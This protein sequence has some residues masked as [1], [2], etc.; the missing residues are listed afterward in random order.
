MRI[1]FLCKRR[2][3]GKDVIA[4]RY[5]RLYEI[6]HQL[7]CLGHT[8]YGFCLSYKSHA[9]GRWEHAVPQGKLVWESRSLPPLIM[10]ELLAYPCTLLK[11]I[12][13]L[14]PDLII[15]ASDIPHVVL[16]AWIA[17]KLDVPYAADLYDNFESFG[18]ARIPG[19]VVALRHAV[20]HADLVTTTSEPLRDLVVEQYHAHGEIIAM[21]S[22][23][24]KAV[25][26]HINREDSRRALGL[27]L[28]AKLVGTAGGLHREKG[29]DTLYSAWPRI[30]AEHSDVELVLAGPID[31]AFPP[32]TGPRVRYLGM[33]PH[34][35]TANLFSALDVGVI[36]LRDTA[37][38]RYCFPQKA[39]EMM[40]CEL[41]IVAARVGV[42][43]HLLE[44]LP[45]TLY[46]PDDAADLARAVSEQL[47]K[48][49]RPRITID[50]WA[51]VIG[52]TELKLRALVSSRRSA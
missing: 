3:M 13:E 49:S 48:P 33:L 51:A 11:R 32:P 7:A 36:Y 5:A 6:P 30:S 44:A 50:D 24:D 35:S 31:K 43:T 20:R 45:D 4:D 12:K 38:G 29:V 10:P 16:G 25:F 9:E 42:M 34:A 28:H 15:G 19:F 14:A 2:Y 17:R 23:V 26:N 40:A 37:F 1:A 18:Q 8:V 22:T 41:P 27:P 21:P 39:Y 46:Q 52:A 47:R